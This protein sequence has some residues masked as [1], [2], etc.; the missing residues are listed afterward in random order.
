MP[1]YAHLTPER[2]ALLRQL[3]IAS[4]QPLLRPLV[5]SF[6]EAA[7]RLLD[8]AAQ[9]GAPVRDLMHLLRGKASNLGADRVAAAAA[10]I[11]RHAQ[12]VPRDTLLDLLDKVRVELELALGDLTRLAGDR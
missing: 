5:E 1:T 10:A 3:E 6:A 11:E 8:E 4:G 2:V 7:P 9:L 12:D